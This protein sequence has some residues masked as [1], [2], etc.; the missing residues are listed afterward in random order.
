MHNIHD[1]LVF[2]LI[3]LISL[4]NIVPS[5]KAQAAISTNDIVYEV[6]V[7]SF[8]DSNGDG[9]G[10]L[11][12]LLSK[13]DYIQ[14]LGAN[15]LWM[16]P[17]HPSP[18][19]H[20]YDIIDY[21][22]IHPDFGTMA[23]MDQLIAAA[24][25]RGMKIILD[26]VVN[27]TSAEHPWFVASS[28][29]TD[30]P[31]RDYYVWKDF[32][33]VKDEIQKKTITFDSDNLTQWHEW[34]GQDDRYYGFFWK[35]MPDLNFD[36]PPVREEIYKIGKFWLDKGIDGFRLDAAKHIYPDDRF[37]DTRL[38]WE[39][40]TKEMRT[41]KPDVKIIG[42]VW[43][44]SMTL[45][46]LFKGLPSLFN[47]ELTKAI[48]ECIL[49]AD[50]GRLIEPY[51]NILKAYQSAGVPFEDA[52]LL[53]N[54]DMNRIRSTLGGDIQKAKLAA[55]ILLTLPGTPYIY[56]GEEIGMLGIKPDI[57]LREPF[58]WGE[59]LLKD[60]RW[61]KSTYSVPPEVES[62]EIQMTDTN[63]IYHHYKKWIALRNEHSLLSRGTPEF[64]NLQNNSILAWT[65]EDKKKTLW[66]IHNLSDTEIILPFKDKVEIV[67]EGKQVNVEDN[68]V[69]SAFSSTLIRMG[70]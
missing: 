33:S 49:A 18:S 4:F 3:P 34:E 53:S 37:N 10:D 36:Y 7:Q 26:L 22:D 54:H 9:I 62:L 60:T 51:L 30:N 52:I 35:G 59:A 16:M 19:Y 29:S 27:H 2:A 61:L 46:T 14:E 42:E 47:F 57:H 15:T 48:P 69:L 32:E 50:A 65:I 5:L 8:C 31:Y 66:V 21:Y 20:K 55:T 28:S 70:K 23:D 24:T 13:L 64:K 67:S 63:S 39:E 38:F 6:Y 45:S 44:D 11:L 68:L 41:L 12:G 40:F 56:Y 43:S 17:I 1:G 25:N 58:L